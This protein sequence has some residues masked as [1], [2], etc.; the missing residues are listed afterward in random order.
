MNTVNQ[1]TTA[2]DGYWDAL[3]KDAEWTEKPKPRGRSTEN[4]PMGEP[5]VANVDQAAQEAVWTWAQDMF[6]KDEVIEGLVTGFN[7]GGLLLKVKELSGFVPASH[8]VGLTRWVSDED[9]A[10]QLGGRIGE[11]LKL[12]IIELNREQNRFILSERL[13]TGRQ[14]DGELLLRTLKIGDLRMGKVNHVTEFG[15][16]VDLGGIDG[17]IH[18]SEISWERI[19]HPSDVL[20]VGQEVQVRVVSIDH[21]K[22]RI[23]LSIKRL[24][25][26][27]WTAVTQKY[28]IGQMITGTITNVTDFGAFVKVDE[29]LE[30]LIH[31]SE[32]AE[33]HFLHPR[34][35]VREGDRVQAKIV[36]VDGQRRRLALTLRLGR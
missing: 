21:T 33:G 14:R 9:R 15:A 19:N 10:Q 25:P 26:D 22:R 7:R 36:S 2:D 8:M 12:K 32:L 29:G 28:Q 23:Q 17:L 20:R 4:E 5:I 31:V 27:P 24:R 3:L 35:I 11:T 18:V 1:K 16:F 13:A 34:S 30:G 6:G